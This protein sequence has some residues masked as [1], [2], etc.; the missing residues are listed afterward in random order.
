[1]SGPGLARLLVAWALATVLA[2]VVAHRAFALD[3]DEAHPREVVASVWRE[4]HV[5]ARALV[6]RAGDREASLDAAAA[7]EGATLVYESVVGEGPV[8]AWPEVALSFSFVPGRDGL[9]ATFGGRTTYVTPDD[10]LAMQAYDHGLSFPSMQI[11]VGLD[12]P[13]A[14]AAATTGLDCS[15]RDL[16]EHGTL[17]R[18]R[19]VRTVAGAPPAR[20]VTPETLDESDVRA[21]AV[22][23]GRYLARGVGEDGRFRYL[24]NAPTD[25]TLPGYDWPRH[26]GATYFLAQIAG[27]TGDPDVGFAALRAGALLRDRA[28]LRCGDARCI[29]DPEGELVDVGSTALA[30]V[31]FVELARTHLDDGYR[32]L[33]PELTA[34]LRA[35]Q[36]TD[37]ELMH[38]YDRRTKRPIDLQLLYYTGEAAFALSRA[39]GLLGD[40]RDRDA[41]TRALERLAGPAWSFFGSR[42]YWGEEHWTC[43]AMDDLWDGLSAPTREKALAFCLGWQAYGRRLMYGPG[44]TP[45]DADGAYGV[46][47][48][49]TPHLTP[50]GSRAE[51]GLATLDAARRAGR[52]AEELAA[53]DR[54]MRRSLAMLLRHQ[55]PAGREYLLVDPAAVSGAMPGSEVD[56]QLRIDY[57]QHAGSALVRWLGL[58]GA[59]SSKK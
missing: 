22:A 46:G 2:C 55:L 14:L 19:V 16:L 26:A 45:F 57:A 18:I 5:V 56:W 8:V 58:A 9:A 34:F 1:M 40:A 52:P 31:A 32:L 49:L 53:L 6:A 29:G 54:Q 24:V 27:L 15:A 38:L 36:R 59:Q 51:A 12:L 30:V 39:H 43:Q 48:V 50:A 35:Q 47:P 42:Y 10:L 44:D 37:G 11:A 23:L 20:V 7:E 21:A 33:V 28:T 25:Q 13:V 4:G 17:R 3:L 41:A